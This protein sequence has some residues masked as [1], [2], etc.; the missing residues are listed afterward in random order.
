[1]KKA[2]SLDTFSSSFCLLAFGFSAMHR[3]Y[4]WPWAQWSLLAGL[5]GRHGMLGIE[6]PGSAIGK[7]SALPAVSHCSSTLRHSEPKETHL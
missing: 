4:S 3:T 7:A 5:R 1:M 2:V 6:E